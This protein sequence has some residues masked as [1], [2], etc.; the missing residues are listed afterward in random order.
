MGEEQNSLFEGKALQID[1][2]DRVRSILD[3]MAAS[4]RMR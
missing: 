2:Q 4:N 3:S 1:D